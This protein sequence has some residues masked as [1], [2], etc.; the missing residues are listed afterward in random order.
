MKTYLFKD[1]KVNLQNSE[2]KKKQMEFFL[3]P[4]NVE[5][6]KLR[7]LTKLKFCYIP[8]SNCDFKNLPLEDLTSS[9]RTAISSELLNWSHHRPVHWAA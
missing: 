2:E 5:I 8:E 9:P 3:H 6:T 7:F 4:V 1:L